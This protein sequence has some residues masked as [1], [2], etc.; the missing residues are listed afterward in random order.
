ML[1]VS[2]KAFPWLL[3]VICYVY[4]NLNLILNDGFGRRNY[5]V[6]KFSV[7]NSLSTRQSHLK[8]YE[9]ILPRQA[10]GMSGKK[11]VVS[12]LHFR[13]RKVARS[14][15]SHESPSSS[16]GGRTN[17]CGTSAFD[18]PAIAVYPWC[19]SSICRV[20]SGISNLVPAT[21]SCTFPVAGS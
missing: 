21:H 8:L 2:K 20:R 3:S 10:S 19:S 12:C 11:T 9:E 14:R 15:I 17:G 6:L 1:Y 4:P 13:L 7:I 16:S 5:G 18:M